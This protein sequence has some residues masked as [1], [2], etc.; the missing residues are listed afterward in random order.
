MGKNTSVVLGE[1]HETFIREQIAK[2][3]YASVSEAVRDAVAVLIQRDAAVEKWLQAEVGPVYDAMR[4][5]PDRGVP[6]D[7]AF[8]ALRRKKADA[9]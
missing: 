2:G 3:R 7:M 6:L 8:R 9:A 5:D 1:A 4:S